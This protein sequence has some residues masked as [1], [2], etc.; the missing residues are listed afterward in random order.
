MTSNGGNDISALV[1]I[2]PV[3]IVFDTGTTERVVA[4]VGRRTRA[5]VLARLSALRTSARALVYSQT[6]S[7]DAIGVDIQSGSVRQWPSFP[8]TPA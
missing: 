8:A 7:G 5:R 1:R 6:S 2:N 3:I 4:Y